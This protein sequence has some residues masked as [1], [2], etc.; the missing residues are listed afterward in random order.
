MKKT[1][2]QRQFVEKELLETGKIGRNY[3][4]Q[5]YISRLGALICDLRADGWDFEAKN[6]KGDYVY[7]LKNSPYEKKH[8]YVDGE[9]V[10]SKW[11]KKL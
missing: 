1:Q 3:C 4:L 8:Y 9:L 6:V 10:A 11:V 5:N 7:K 2:T